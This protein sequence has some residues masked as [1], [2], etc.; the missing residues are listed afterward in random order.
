MFQVRYVPRG[1][2]FP[3]TSWN[4]D[5][6]AP[7]PDSSQIKNCVFNAFSSRKLLIEISEIVGATVEDVWIKQN[8]AVLSEYCYC[9]RRD[10]LLGQNR[11][12]ISYQ[13]HP[14][15]ERIA[16]RVPAQLAWAAQLTPGV[17]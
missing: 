14:S 4:Q 2:L 12:V 7:D 3:C 8:P 9:P 6:D 5:H 11:C 17:K 16:E 1:S 13:Y 10:P 15:N